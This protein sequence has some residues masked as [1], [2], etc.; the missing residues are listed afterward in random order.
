MV[1]PYCVPGC[2]LLADDQQA[3]EESGGV[4]GAESA[5]HVAPDEVDAQ[6][7]GGGRGELVEFDARF[8]L[9]GGEVV[10]TLRIAELEALERRAHAPHRLREGEG[11]GERRVFRK[12]EVGIADG[13]GEE[14]HRPPS[15]NLPASDRAAG[16]RRPAAPAD[17]AARRARRTAGSRSSR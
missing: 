15:P 11:D 2:S 3:R 14:L 9:H 5:A 8:D 6:R 7:A 12:G 4:G 10:V 16:R 17:P 13:N 1:S